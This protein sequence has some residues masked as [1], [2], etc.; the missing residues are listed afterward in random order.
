MTDSISIG[1][2]SLRRLT[3]VPVQVRP[4]CTAAQ[5]AEKNAGSCRPLSRMPAYRP[6]I[7]DGWY[8]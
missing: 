7:S 5:M 6:T 3:I 8:P 4:A 1:V 2:P